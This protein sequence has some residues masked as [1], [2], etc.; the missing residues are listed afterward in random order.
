MS[1]VCRIGDDKD[2]KDSSARGN[3][4]TSSRVMA[5][6]GE[7]QRTNIIMV[8][9]ESRAAFKEGLILIKVL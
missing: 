6:K 3:E 9:G 2:N 5:H 1:G 4:E 8:D 7:S